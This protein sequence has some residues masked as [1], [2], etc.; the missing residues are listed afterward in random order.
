[1]HGLRRRLS[2][3]RM[4][5]HLPADRSANQRVTSA[6][7]SFLCILMCGTQHTYVQSKKQAKI[8]P[9]EN[10]KRAGS[11][12]LSWDLRQ[13][14]ANVLSASF[15]DH[16][17]KLATK[18]SADRSA[19]FGRLR[20]SN[21]TAYFPLPPN[22]KTPFGFVPRIW[23]PGRFSGDVETISHVPMSCCLSV[24]PCCWARTLLGT[25]ATPSI[26]E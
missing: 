19:A 15:T 4:A 2:E 5:G 23:A 17:P 12:G 1:M 13:K 26:A 21:V 6:G 11:T 9:V 18:P 24:V 16:V 20:F 3:P 14:L 7:D 8:A 25:R 10:S 22:I